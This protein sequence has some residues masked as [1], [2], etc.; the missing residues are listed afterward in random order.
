MDVVTTSCRQLL[1]VIIIIV[2][3]IIVVIFIAVFIVGIIMVIVQ[4][5]V[6]LLHCDVIITFEL[7]GRSLVRRRR[8][9][10]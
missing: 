10:R 8:G 6:S 7:R 3:V 5:A 2:M 9:E 4:V 1:V